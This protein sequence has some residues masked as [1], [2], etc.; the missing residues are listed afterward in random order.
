MLNIFSKLKE[1]RSSKSSHPSAEPP[2]WAPAQETVHQWGLYNESSEEDYQAAIDF[3][4]RYPLQPPRLVPSN[5]LDVIRQE[6]SRAWGIQIPS[7]EIR[8]FSGKITNISL[9]GAPVVIVETDDRCG[10]FCLMSDLPIMAGLYDVSRQNGVYF[11]V[12]IVKMFPP[13]SYLAIGTACQ[14]YPNFRFPGWN[15]E[16]A[17]LHLDDLRKF[18]EDPDGGRDYNVPFDRIRG[19]DIIGCGYEYATSSLFYTW[20]GMR[21]ENAFHGIY[22]PRNQYDVFAAIGVHGGVHFEV[23]YGGDVFKWKE[24][25]EWQWK[26]DGVFA[27][28][29]D[30]YGD[31]EELPAYS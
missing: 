16:S 10:S 5:A 26:V 13:Q 23:N 19:G 15:R 31:G 18:F 6:G 11:E 30:T 2:G 22:L 29:G 17:G 12:K 8:R 7:Q 25:N 21:L 1:G 3:C 9:K 14:P 4:L 28:L 20:N 24:G 27:R